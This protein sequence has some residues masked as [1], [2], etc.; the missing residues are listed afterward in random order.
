MSD[1]AG[2]YIIGAAIWL[3]AMI[4]LGK[5]AIKSRLEYLDY[6]RKTERLRREVIQK[7]Y[8]F[9]GERQPSG[10]TNRIAPQGQ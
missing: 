5:W 6:R 2:L 8:G 9:K 1:N 3:T 4:Q 7:E 10:R